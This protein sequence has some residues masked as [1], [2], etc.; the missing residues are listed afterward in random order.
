MIVEGD[1]LRLGEVGRRQDRRDGERLDRVVGGVG[2]EPVGR[3][4]ELARDLRGIDVRAV[5]GGHAEVAREVLETE[6]RQIARPGV[7]DLGEDVGVDHVAAGHVVAPVPDRALG[8]LQTG[9]PAPQKGA[10]AAPRERDAMHPG[11]RLQV[12]EV[13]AEDVVALDH[14]GIALADDPRAL[15]QERRLVEPVAPHHVAKP[16][17][18]GESDR[19]D[20]IP[21]AR[22]AGELV[23]LGR[24]HLDVEREPPQVREHEPAER[25]AARVE[26]ILMNRVPQEEIRRPRHVRRLAGQI[27]APIARAHGIAPRSEAGSPPQIARPLERLDRHETRRVLD[28]LAVGQEHEGRERRGLRDGGLAH[29]AI[30]THGAPGVG[31]IV[32]DEPGV[33]IPSEQERSVLD[34]EHA[35]RPGPPSRA[36]DN[37]RRVLAQP[38]GATARCICSLRSDGASR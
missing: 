4:P 8:D 18:V 9:H 34:G 11:P 2:H 26:Q 16:R 24:D 7:L 38:P 22:G 36:Q 30:E 35:T 25:R 14:V 29:A 6:P 10:V 13:E 23:A 37:R 3:V 33:R 20:P 1:D 32:R 12:L 19:D 28:E 31:E 5:G 17:G 21:R 15:G 27:A